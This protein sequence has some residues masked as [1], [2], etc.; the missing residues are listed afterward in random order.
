M[1]GEQ[2]RADRG[3][4]AVGGDHQVSL[5]RCPVGQFHGGEFRGVAA[6]HHAGFAG[7]SHRFQRLAEHGQEI[8]TEQDVQRIAVPTGEGV[9]LLPEDPG[10]VG[11][12]SA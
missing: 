2:F 7:E 6:A 10:A 9:R 3:L 12:P 1:A 11:P 8:R 5:E 4:P